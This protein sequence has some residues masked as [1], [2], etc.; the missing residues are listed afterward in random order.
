M[1]APVMSSESDMRI[2]PCLTIS[3]ALI[4]NITCDA[5]VDDV[6]HAEPTETIM[7]F[8]LRQFLRSVLQKDLLSLPSNCTFFINASIRVFGNMFGFL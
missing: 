7:F 1:F 4:E 8:L 6:E 5:F 3:G 2:T